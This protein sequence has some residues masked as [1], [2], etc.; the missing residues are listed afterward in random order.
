LPLLQRRAQGAHLSLIVAGN[1]GAMG[2]MRLVASA[3]LRQSPAVEVRFL[4]NLGTSGGIAAAL[5]GAAG[6]AIAAREPNEVERA[7][8]ARSLA[9]GR[10]P[11]ALAVHPSI[12]VRDVTRADLARIFSGDLAAWPDGSAIRPVR[13]PHNDSVTLTL[14]GMSPRMREAIEMLQRRPGIPTAGNDQDAAD[15][16]ES[17]RGSFGAITL[18]QHRTEQRQL[19]L[20]SLDGVP[21]TVEAMVSDRYPLATTLRAVTSR[22]PPPGVSAFQEFMASTEGRA[23]LS[24]SGHQ[25]LS[26]EAFT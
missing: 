18:A 15:A 24:A 12:A 6:L 2:T 17:V 9:Y 10:T 22:N 26:T 5:Q 11:F 23:L 3:L 16:M 7:S 8:G 20:V 13:R 21:P 1:G 25:P 4:P 19:A 14:A